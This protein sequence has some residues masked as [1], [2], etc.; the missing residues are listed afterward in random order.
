MSTPHVAGAAALVLAQ[1]PNFTPVDIKN[2]LM[3]TVDPV[4]SLTGR[5]VTGGRLNVNRALTIAATAT[6]I[7]V[8][9]RGTPVNGIYPIMVVRIDGNV[10]GTFNVNSSVFADYALSVNVAAATAHAIDIVFTNDGFA[11]PEDRNLIVQSLRVNA[12]AFLPGTAGVTYDRGEGNAA[13][14]G[15]DVLAGQEGMWWSGALR[16][17]IPSNAF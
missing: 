13:F 15:V 11:A 17:T 1:F 9:A 7:T 8:V 3:Q 2:R 6:P 10:V 4:P 14:D 12:T 16:F 5:T